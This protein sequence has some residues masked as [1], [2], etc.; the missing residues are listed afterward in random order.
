MTTQ[1]VE[2]HTERRRTRI[3]L[4]RIAQPEADGSGWIVL[5]CLAGAIAALFL[6]AVLS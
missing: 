4:D 1:Q 5:L 6:G 3:M 2:L